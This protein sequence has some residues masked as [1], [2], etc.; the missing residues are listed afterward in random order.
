M[1]AAIEAVLEALERVGFQ[2][3]P[4]PL[5]VSGTSFDFDAA[6]T[7]TGVS[8]DLVVVSA[9]DHD[10]ERLLQL[11]SGLNRS[12]DRTASRRPV[13]LLLLGTRPEHGVLAELEAH[14][15]VLLME[16]DSPAP[17]DV[18]DAVAVLLP[19]HIPAATQLA[20]EP[21]DELSEHLGDTMT[22]EHHLLVDAAR[23]GPEAVRSAF[24]AMLEASIGTV[25]AEGMGE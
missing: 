3:L 14:A 16:D 25:G 7:G 23:V 9:G 6:V 19:L 13:S 24:Q 8:N 10:P 11:L 20:T 5:A 12:L 18:H 15:R 17:D 1:T 21:L 22:D 2:R 4:K